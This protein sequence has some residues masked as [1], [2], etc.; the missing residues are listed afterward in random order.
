MGRW[1]PRS[2]PLRLGEDF[3]T[4]IVPGDHKECTLDVTPS[5]TLRLRRNV[6]WKGSNGVCRSRLVGSDTL[7]WFTLFKISFRVTVVVDSRLFLVLKRSS[8]KTLFIVVLSLKVCLGDVGFPWGK[9][10]NGD[11]KWKHRTSVHEP[12]KTLGS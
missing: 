9:E 6:G 10:R 5:F 1:F 12:R 2:S 11:L 4:D 3:D 7:M 8:A